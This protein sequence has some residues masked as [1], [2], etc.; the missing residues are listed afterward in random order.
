MVIVWPCA[1]P[2]LGLMEE[3]TGASDAVALAGPVAAVGKRATATEL[4]PTNPHRRTRRLIIR[5]SRSLTAAH[6]PGTLTGPR[7][8]PHPGCR[9]IDSRESIGEVWRV[10]G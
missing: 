7:A 6:S 4:T 10:Q 9:P 3:I 2:R 8:E 1:I 5:N